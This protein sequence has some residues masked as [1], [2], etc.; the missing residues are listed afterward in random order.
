MPL[1]RWLAVAAVAVL[2]SSPTARAAEETKKA[3]KEDSSFGALKS[4]DAAEARKQTDAWL[5]SVGKT[6]AA[7]RAKVN[8]VWASERPV[9]DKV[10]ATLALGDDA[11]AR[12]LADARDGSKAAPTEV[13]ALLRDKAR[14]AFYR[15]NLAL[16]YG[17]ALTGRKVYEEGLEALLAVRAEDATDP[18]ALL[19]HRAVCEYQLML[20]DRAEATIDRLL[21]D[22]GDSPERYR[23]VGALMHLDMLTWQEKDLGWIARK[24]GNIQ[25]RLDLKRGGQKTQKEQK[26]VLVRLDEMIKEKENQQKSQQSPGDPNGGADV[27]VPGPDGPDA[28][29]TD[30]SSS[31][32][33]DTQGGTANGKGEVDL[34]KVKETAEAWGKL[35][36]KE[37][38]QAMRDLIRSLPAK[39][40]AVIEAYL[41]EIQKRSSK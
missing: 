4:P 41:R 2:V 33:K 31:P 38:A 34:K 40:R 17:K 13:P 6:D 39:D 20:K 36:E 28:P 12:L 8:E 7:T 11:A 37:R 10:A 18:A 26:E 19:F 1:N 27:P 23:T 21:V 16:A 9:L 14:P 35:P 29:G 15:A 5:A 3:A 22:V 24:M 32:Q 30:K 25:R